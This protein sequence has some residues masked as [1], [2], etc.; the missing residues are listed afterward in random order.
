LK[1]KKYILLFYILAISCL[2]LKGQQ[3]GDNK[4][5]Y[6]EPFINKKL[7]LG[8]SPAISSPIIGTKYWNKNYGTYYGLSLYYKFLILEKISIGPVFT[9][10]HWVKN[11]ERLTDYDTEYLWGEIKGALDMGDVSLMCRYSLLREYRKTELFLHSSAGYRY[12]KGFYKI[13]GTKQIDKDKQAYKLSEKEFEFYNPGLN[14]GFGIRCGA[15]EMFPTYNIIFTI[16]QPTQ[17]VN[18][19]IGF[20]F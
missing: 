6:P 17:Y 16:G 7:K 19:N 13:S 20:V 1:N 18:V 14:V 12:I 15:F 10:N 11:D 2:S 3:A 8:I 4:V 9:Y 5:K